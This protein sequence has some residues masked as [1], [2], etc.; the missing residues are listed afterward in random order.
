MPKKKR[1]K[2]NS[3]DDAFAEAA[4]ALEAAAAKLAEMGEDDIEIESGPD[5]F[6]SLYNKHRVEADNG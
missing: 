3:A 4:E 6:P 2:L 5:G 1:P